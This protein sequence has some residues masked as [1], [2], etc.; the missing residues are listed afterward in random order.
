MELER[1]ERMRREEK[2][3]EEC[4]RRDEKE[5]DRLHLQMIAMLSGG[6]VKVP[7]NPRVIIKPS[8]LPSAP[9]VQI[10]IESLPQLI[11]CDVSHRNFL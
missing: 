8:N 9:A 11:R 3:K 7:M 1:Y 2:D 5:R 10:R 6:A 4:R